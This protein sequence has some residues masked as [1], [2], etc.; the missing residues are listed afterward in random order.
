MKRRV[1]LLLPF[2]LLSAFCILSSLGKSEAQ[3]VELSDAQKVRIAEDREPET[4]RL[5]SEYP[6]V[7]PEPGTIIYA[8]D[9]LRS[10][11]VS[12]D[13][14][15]PSVYLTDVQLEGLESIG[16]SMLMGM[17]FRP[18]DG[19]LYGLASDGFPLRER[20]VKINPVSGVV[21]PVHPS[22]TFASIIDSFTGFDFD[23]TSSAIRE[24]GNARSNRRLNPDSSSLIAADT[25]LT[26][27]AGDPNFG[28]V[29]KVVHTAYDFP[30]SG[31]ATLYG[32]DSG[33]NSLVRIGGNQGQPS[34]NS[35]ELTTIGNLGIDVTNFGG[36]DIQQGTNLAYAS[37]FLNSAPVLVRINLQTG[38]AGVVGLIGD[39]SGI[40]DGLSIPMVWGPNPAL[41][42]TPTPTPPAGRRVLRTISARGSRNDVVDVPI[43]F[44]SVGGETSLEFSI[45]VDSSCLSVESAELGGAVPSGTT[46]I[47]D[48]SL[49]Q[50][51][52]YGFMIR[53]QSPFT[54][55]AYRVLNTRVKIGSTCMQSS[56]AV[57]FGRRPI[58]FRTSGPDGAFYETSYLGG[59]VAVLNPVVPT[60]ATVSGTVNTSDGRG[61]SGVTVTLTDSTGIVQYSARTGSF[62]HYNF[63]T[64]QPGKTYIVKGI[65]SRYSFVPKVLTVNDYITNFNLAAN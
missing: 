12:F 30:S 38:E 41:D 33:T 2:T 5:A 44:I 55:G 19:L 63:P 20:I 6:Q 40:I 15:N 8:Y 36:F 50:S 26:Y 65:S 14:S 1:A 39:G 45:N 53:A 35:G 13:A 23:P 58:S 31:G 62:G 10:R 60:H 22:T 37:L 54:P 52:R 64:V 25:L 47:T 27:R 48:N 29:P 4:G 28:V 46:L 21:T 3:V 7:N 24:V 17:D 18:S 32:I 57:A 51:G 11:L 61:L 56:S 16:A 49:R 59:T 43:E 34:A 42:P 9:F